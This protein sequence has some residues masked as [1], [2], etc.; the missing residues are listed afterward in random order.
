MNKRCRTIAA[1]CINGADMRSRGHVLQS[2]PTIRRFALFVSRNRR[3]IICAESWKRKSDVSLN[4]R[5]YL[6]PPRLMPCAELIPMIWDGSWDDVPGNLSDD[7]D[8]IQ[9]AKYEFTATTVGPELPPDDRFWKFRVTRR[10]SSRRSGRFVAEGR[11]CG[12][13]IEAYKSLISVLIKKL[14]INKKAQNGTKREGQG[15]MSDDSGVGALTID[16][17]G[18][19]R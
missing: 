9:N 1:P 18:A 10:I 17:P 12:D 5:K 19:W 3:Q 14:Q 7:E 11:A 13:A 2:I 15:V 4:P 16:C 8:G 6:V